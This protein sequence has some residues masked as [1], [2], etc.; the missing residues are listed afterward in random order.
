M[1]DRFTTSFALLG[2]N[3]LAIYSAAFAAQT[4]RVYDSSWPPVPVSAASV[5]AIIDIAYSYAKMP[6]DD[7]IE[8]GAASSL[9]GTHLRI[10]GP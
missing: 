9:C 2:T 4:K 10:L 1:K 5:V 3:D 6:V 8:E 7:A